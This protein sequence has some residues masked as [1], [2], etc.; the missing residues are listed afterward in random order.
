[1]KLAEALQERSDLNNKIDELR[2]RISVSCLVQEGEQPIE[3]PNELVAELD[4]A[5]QRLNYLMAKINRT[6]NLTVV[7]GQT[8]TEIIAE[9]DSLTVQHS[10]YKHIIAVASRQTDRARGSE[11]KIVSCLNI[12]ELQKKLDS[13]CKRIRILDNKLQ[14]SNWTNDLI[15]D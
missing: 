3:N 9:K 13:V 11:I 12:A 1:M 6:N 4:S 2:N 8:L 15:E 14:Q 10:A 7:D 5:I